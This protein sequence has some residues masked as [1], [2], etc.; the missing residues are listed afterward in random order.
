[1]HG[2]FGRECTFNTMAAMGPDFKNG[3]ADEAPVSNA[4]IAP[5]IAHVL[6]LTLPST[7]VLKGRV[8]LEAL[9]DAAAAAAAPVKYLASAS[10]GGT[11][12]AMYFQELD[13]ERYNITAC[14]VADVTGIRIAARCRCQF[15]PCRAG[16]T[17]RE[18]A[19]PASAI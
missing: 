8:V 10:A 19:A 14:R 15:R 4:D 12:T 9:R 17:R 18:S 2:G 3:F 6:G 13:G 7:G 5:T 16:G 11:R 1:M